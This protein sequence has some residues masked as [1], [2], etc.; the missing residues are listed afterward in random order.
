MRKVK[1]YMNGS[2]LTSRALAWF[3]IFAA[4]C[5]EPFPP[6]QGEGNLNLLVVD[7]FLNSTAGL[8][9]VKL[10][11]SLPLEVVGFFPAE[12]AA[13]VRVEDENGNRFTLSEVEAGIYR[14]N[15]ALTV[16][17]RYR[18]LIQTLNGDTYESDQVLLKQSPVLEDLFWVP[19]PD[20]ITIKVDSRDP[21][22]STR[23]YQ[24]FYTETWE[25][26]S[27]RSSPIWVQNGRPQ[28]RRTSEMINICYSSSKSSKVLISSTADQSGDVIND[29][30][31]VFIP[32][33][34]KKL[35]R[36]YSISVQQRALDEESYKY[37]LQLQQ[38]NENLGGLFD[39]LPTQVTGNIHS[40]NAAPKIALGYFSGGGVEEKRIYIR[41]I[42]LPSDLLTVNRQF[43]PVDSI[44]TRDLEKY[45]DG[46]PLMGTYGAFPTPDGYTTTRLSCLDCRTEGGVLEKPS[47]WPN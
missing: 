1:E 20:G 46:F 19:G 37:W 27:D 42:D 9:E 36:T 21:D 28:L 29:Y 16:G 24:W 44:L 18:L 10:S 15:L 41:F 17:K 35:C 22:A 32:K 33:G 31:L 4:A 34:S 39:P 7:G 30:P 6:P 11:R 3:M 23:Y 13:T 2:K 47:F 26:D 12:I 25:Y 38:T 5:L 14:A 8:A 40:T 45:D 43:C